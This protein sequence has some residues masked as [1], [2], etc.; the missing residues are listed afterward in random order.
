MGTLVATNEG[1]A[2][3]D[4]FK[5]SRKTTYCYHLPKTHWHSRDEWH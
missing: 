3:P 4:I 1:E 5:R 2:Q